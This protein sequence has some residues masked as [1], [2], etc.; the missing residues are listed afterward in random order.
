MQ[1]VDSWK[2]AL[3]SVAEPSNHAEMVSHRDIATFYAWVGDV[4][5]ALAWMERAFTWSHNPVEFR[6][7][8]SGVFDNVRDDPRFR[9]GFEQ[10]RGRM[11]ER[12]LQEGV[13]RQ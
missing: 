7:M 10:I 9:S 12:L 4:D 8:A 5:E 1:S 6:V 2:S 3:R 13:G 11:R